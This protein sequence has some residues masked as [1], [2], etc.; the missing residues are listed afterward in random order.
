[1]S[2][3]V[4]SLS[5]SASAAVCTPGSTA[6]GCSS[7]ITTVIDTYFS[8]PVVTVN[9]AAFSETVSAGEITYTVP[10]M[11]G[12]TVND[13]RGN[14]QGF[15]LSLTA[16]NFATSLSSVVIPAGDF[17]LNG[18][19]AATLTSCAALNAPVGGCGPVVGIP[20]AYPGSSL[21]VPRNF[22]L[23]CPFEAEGVGTYA[24]TVPLLL[25]IPMDSPEDFIFAHDISWYGGFNVTLTE[26]PSVNFGSFGC[27]S[28][29]P[30][31]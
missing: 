29:A 20:G 4:F 1:M 28:I 25:V 22:A 2:L 24:L 15:V 12:V 9:T 8:P 7:S 30:V 13:Y 26:G 14:N 23:Q 5:Q 6:P 16:T 11:L 21:D 10:G 19:T 3:P 31:P 18:T 17:Y 27:A